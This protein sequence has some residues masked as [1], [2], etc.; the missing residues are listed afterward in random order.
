MIRVPRK[1][2]SFYFQHEISIETNKNT[3]KCFSGAVF[4][5]FCL[6]FSFRNNNAQS[7]M[8]LNLIACHEH[9]M[10]FRIQKLAK[11][12][13]LHGM[14]TFSFPLTSRFLPPCLVLFGRARN[15]NARIKLNSFSYTLKLSGSV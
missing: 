7:E 9:L 15:Q 1:L 14:S 6:A 4:P 10:I 8:M 12:F 3:Q 5:P 11:H 13:S 2:A